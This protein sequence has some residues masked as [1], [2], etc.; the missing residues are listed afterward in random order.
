MG[1]DRCALCRRLEL[2]QKGIKTLGDSYLGTQKYFLLNDALDILDLHFN[3]TCRSN[4]ILS[5]FKI[6]IIKT[7]G[8]DRPPVP[9]EKE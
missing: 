6:K 1:R 3:N 9:T 5:K 4:A 2:M 8:R 7:L